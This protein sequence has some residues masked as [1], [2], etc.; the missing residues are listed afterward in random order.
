MILIL[1]LVLFIR[2]VAM[3]FLDMQIFVSVK[4]A[5]SPGVNEYDLMQW[6]ER[7]YCCRS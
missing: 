1:I 2:L 3:R 4:K 7:S 5:K 6:R